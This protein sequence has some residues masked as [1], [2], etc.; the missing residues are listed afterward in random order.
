[1]A[2]RLSPL[3][4]LPPVL[5]AAFAVMA[6]FG[7]QR[8]NPEDLPS[9]FLGKQAPALPAETLAVKAPAVQTRRP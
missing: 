1:M 7:M 5:F 2:R 4:I 9:T 3:M 8:E 6:Y